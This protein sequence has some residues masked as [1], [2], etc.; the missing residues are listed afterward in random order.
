MS[1]N[2]PLEIIDLAKKLGPRKYYPVPPSIHVQYNYED[3]N[4]NLKLREDVTKFFHKKVIKWINKD[5]NFKK[6]SDKLEFFES[7]DG[8]LHIYKLL[9]NFVKK[10]NVNWWDLRETNYHLIKDYLNVFL[11]KT[12]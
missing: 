9:R 8:Y 7:S 2:I 12:F 11:T 10:S 3:H 5:S 6:Y 1:F 4:E